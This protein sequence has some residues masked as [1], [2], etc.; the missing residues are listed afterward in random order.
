MVSFGGFNLILPGDL[1]KDGLM[2]LFKDNRPFPKVD[3][4]MAPHHGRESGEP[5]LCARGFKPRFVVLSDWR[6]YPDDHL[7]Y[8][9]MVPGAV[10]LSTAEEGCIE[11]EISPKG[12]GRYRTFLDDQWKPFTYGK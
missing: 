12:V 6:D 7:V 1:E 3:W 2:K 9:S 11:V 8:Q 5:A 4:L 10:V